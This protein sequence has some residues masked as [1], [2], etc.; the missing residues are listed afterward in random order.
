MVLKEKCHLVKGSFTPRLNKRFLPSSV[1]LP[2]R[3][4]PKTGWRSAHFLPSLVAGQSSS[5]GFVAPVMNRM[6]GMKSQLVGNS[7]ALGMNR[8]TGMK[9]Q[10]VGNSVALGMN[11]MTGMKSQLVG[12][13]VAPGLNRMTGTKS[14]LV[15]LSLLAW[16][17]WQVQKVSC[18]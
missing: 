18:W 17:E 3:S 6:T 8:M 13:S 9:S 16:T 1:S 14:Q 15:I 12:N 11:R 7:V 10:L 2:L 5:A 4:A